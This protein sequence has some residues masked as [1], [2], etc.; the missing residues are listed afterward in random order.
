[1]A[2]EYT[3]AVTSMKVV[4]TVDLENVV[5][6]TYWTKTGIDEDGNEGIF[7][8][9]TPLP[10]SS[11]DPENFVPY[12]QLTQEIVIGWIQ[13]SLTDQTHIDEQIQKQINNKKNPVVEK[14]LP[15]APSANTES[16]NTP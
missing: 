3:W 6:Q 2:I 16:A 15:W 1:M 11:L 5:I 14:P 4:D 10:Y 12:D 8:G 9:A 7:T 13:Q